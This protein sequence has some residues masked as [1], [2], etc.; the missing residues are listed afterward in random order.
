MSTVPTLTGAIIPASL[1]LQP[2]TAPWTAPASCQFN[3]YLQDTDQSYVYLDDD[4]NGNGTKEI[5]YPPGML[6][7]GNGLA[8]PG[9]FSPAVCPIGW[10]TNN[11]ALY[12]SATTGAVCCSSRYTFGPQGY[13]YSPT[14]SATVAVFPEFTSVSMSTVTSITLRIHPITALW[15]QSDLA[16]LASLSSSR[17]S[18]STLMGLFPSGSSSTAATTDDPSTPPAST[19]DDSPG[20]LSRGAKI[21]IGVGVS[22]AFLVILAAVITLFCIRRKKTGPESSPHDASAELHGEEPEPKVYH[23]AGTPIVPELDPTTSPRAAARLS[24]LEAGSPV[25]FGS[26]EMEGRGYGA[27]FA[28][29]GQAG[30]PYQRG[31]SQGVQNVSVE[32]GGQEQAQTRWQAPEASGGYAGQVPVAVA[33]GD[34]D[35]YTPSDT[36]SGALERL[37]AEKTRLEAKRQ[38]LMEI[39]EAEEQQRNIQRQIEEL[40]RGRGNRPL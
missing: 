16:L 13:C 14:S 4:R 9:I 39:E 11:L 35:R 32:N 10:T 17:A 3:L 37:R 7:S 24:E 25:S 29:W 20:G 2:L 38:R 33:G 27:G 34:G 22:V 26:H 31:V 23:L 1:T 6:V 19:S 28:P 21:G 40:E 12:G 8:Y 18:T 15:Q 5:C 36:S 30:S